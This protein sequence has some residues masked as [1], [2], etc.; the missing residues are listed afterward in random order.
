MYLWAS[1]R[2]LLKRQLR[3]DPTMKSLVPQEL[4]HIQSPLL[5]PYNVS[6]YLWSEAHRLS[7]IKSSPINVSKPNQ[8]GSTHPM[9]V[10]W[11]IG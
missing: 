7:Q 2:Y 4:I 8:H 5:S 1:S 6:A 9:T 10:F 11:L 3:P